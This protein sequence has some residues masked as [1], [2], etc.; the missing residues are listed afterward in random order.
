V[1]TRAK[2]DDLHRIEARLDAAD[3]AEELAGL[4]QEYRPDRP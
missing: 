4:A 1:E 2:I 3:L